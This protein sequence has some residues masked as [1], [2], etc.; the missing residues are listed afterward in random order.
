MTTTSGAVL[1]AAFLLLSPVPIHIRV[2]QP[3]VHLVR[4]LGG[5]CVKLMAGPFP[6]AAPC[7]ILVSQRQIHYGRRMSHG[8]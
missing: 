7:R 8:R 2:T 4:W 1:A 3:S 6:G 5:G